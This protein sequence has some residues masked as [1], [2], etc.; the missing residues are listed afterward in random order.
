MV[1]RLVLVTAFLAGCGGDDSG[2]PDAAP[3]IDAAP[4][5]DAPPPR[6]DVEDFYDPAN[7]PC[8]VDLDCANP[9]SRCIPIGRLRNSPKQCIPACETRA[10]CPFGT[11][12]YQ[13]D[14]PVL[15]VDLMKGHCWFSYCGGFFENGTNGMACQQGLDIP[16]Q[17]AAETFSG[18]CSPIDD[19]FDSGLDLGECQEAGSVPPGG[20][21][22]WSYET[23][24]HDGDN[25][26]SSS[27]CIG[28]AMGGTCL[29]W[30]DP[31]QIPLG[32]DPGCEPGQGCWDRSRVATYEDGT[33][34]E[35]TQAWCSDGVIPCQT[36]GPNTCP[37]D[38]TTLEPQAC[39]FSNS[40]RPTGICAV[41][42]TGALALGASCPDDPV[43]D[44]E[45][46]AA[47]T[48]CFGQ[49]G[50]RTCHQLCDVGAAPVAP[51]PIDETCLTFYWDDGFDGTNGT[52][53]DNFTFG[54]GTCR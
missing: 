39:A 44:A 23:R 22:D 21:C 33:I 31:R 34:Q 3:P 46:C 4:T 42:A 24:T 18:Y 25:C 29:S 2:D 41:E 51:C 15:G 38:E 40:L 9:E 45:E 43:G 48:I 50:T 6:G 14:S 20:A 32:G 7:G 11:V 36:V 52:P 19:T 54:W 13:S 49:A 8:I 28:N 53:D 30:C 27:L 47:G 26:D 37:P 12:C 35:R 1:R 5:A 10:D 17:P 16:G